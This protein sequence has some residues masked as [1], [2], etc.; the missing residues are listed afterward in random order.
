[1]KLI[2]ASTSKFKT[3]ILNKVGL[4]HI[5]IDSHYDESLVKEKNPYKKVML[6]ALNKANNINEEGIII[7]L[8]TIVLVGNKILEKPKDINDARKYIE[9][10][11]N[12]V[13]K[14]ITGYAIK[15]GDKIINSYDQTNIKFKKIDEEGINYYLKNEKDLL[16]ASGFII[17]GVMSNY[18]KYIKGSFYN[19]LGVP[20]NKIYDELKRLGYKYI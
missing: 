13:I 8:D 7:G 10:S 19:I 6:L 16:Y 2:L 9:Y 15:Y 5:N 14:V 12:K 1:M 3:E 17:E 18:I 4:K 20:V 11:S